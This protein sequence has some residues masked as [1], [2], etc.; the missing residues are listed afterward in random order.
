MERPSQRSRKGIW[1]DLA[2]GLKKFVQSIENFMNS[3]GSAI[4]NGLS[5][6]WNKIKGLFGGASPINYEGGGGGFVRGT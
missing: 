3:L 2:N 5:A 1:D 6:I 4:A